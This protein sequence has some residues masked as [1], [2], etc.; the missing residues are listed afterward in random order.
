MCASHK[1]LVIQSILK[2][3]R[4]VCTF[5]GNLHISKAKKKKHLTGS[6][7]LALCVISE[8]VSIEYMVR[9]TSISS[10]V[11]IDLV[12]QQLTSN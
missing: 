6:L 11:A 8:L 3:I 4:L 12:M 10:V 1:R 9:F 2:K 7:E 5:P